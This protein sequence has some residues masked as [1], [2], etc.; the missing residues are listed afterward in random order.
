MGHGIKRVHA[1]GSH[2]VVTERWGVIMA[3][4]LHAWLPARGLLKLNANNPAARQLPKLW[5]PCVPLILVVEHLQQDVA[6]LHFLLRQQARGL[7]V[8]PVRLSLYI[9][10]HH[11]CMLGSHTHLHVW[12]RAANEPGKTAALA[13]PSTNP[14][15]PSS[16]LK[17]SSFPGPIVAPACKRPLSTSCVRHTGPSATSLPN[18]NGGRSPHLVFQLLVLAQQ[19][20]TELRLR[21]AGAEQP[22]GPARCMDQKLSGTQLSGGLRSPFAMLPRKRRCCVLKRGLTVSAHLIRSVTLFGLRTGAK[23]AM[24]ATPVCVDATAAAR[25]DRRL[26][27]AQGMNGR[28]PCTRWCCTAAL[29]HTL[30]LTKLFAGKSLRKVR[31][32]GVSAWGWIGAQMWPPTHQAL[33]VAL[34]RGGK[35]GMHCARLDR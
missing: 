31:G 35:G 13:G 4:I 1:W 17:S 3:G 10:H 7:L 11:Q 33:P 14:P 9:L 23:N 21:H 8:G 27:G 12:T 2:H 19:L 16:T 34:E 29:G 32:S 5:R 18:L 30:L 26:R 24:V 22:V 25:V 28:T 20:G 6:V 15:A